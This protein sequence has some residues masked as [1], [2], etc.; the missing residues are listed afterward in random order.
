M[1]NS[2][3]LT[4]LDYIIFFATLVVVMLVGFIVGRKE[5]TSENYFLAGRSIRWFGVA[6]GLEGSL[7]GYRSILT[8]H[9]ERLV[10]QGV[11]Y[12]EIMVGSSELPHG[13]DALASMEEF[14]QWLAR[15]EDGRIQVEFLLAF[16][17]TRPAEW[18][19]ALL[20]R[21]LPFLE[22]RLLVGLAVI[23]KIV[24]L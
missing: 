7:D 16:S 6:H 17:R 1:T 9:I 3:D 12:A 5:D 2:L 15:I 21:T 19:D 8:Q 13:E 4:T 23:Q 11:R 14:R 18:L 20:D 24:N 22:N 10:S